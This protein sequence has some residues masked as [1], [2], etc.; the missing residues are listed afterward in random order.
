MV[1]PALAEVC[2]QAVYRLGVCRFE[3][4]DM[5]EAVT[6]FEQLLSEFP[7]SLL[8]ASASFFCGEACTRLGR[9]LQAVK[10]LQ[11]VAESFPSDP[12]CGPAMLRLGEAQAALQRWSQSEEVFGRYLD[13]FADSQVW[14]QAR[15]G[16]GWARE[17]QG[18]HDEAIDAYRQV[19]NRHQGPT[20]ARAQFQIGE[21][22]FAKKDYDNAIRELLKVDILYAHPQWSAA[23]LY[24]AGRCFEA[25]SQLGQARRQFTQ[26][27][28][29]YDQT[30]WAQ[31]A[32]TR[33]TELARS[34]PPNP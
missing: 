14:F 6:L 34:S 33:L 17:N 11:R 25:L 22:L 29:K 12:A 15:F 19:V 3:L 27:A 23:A 30:R 4:G 24:E 7:E 10:H 20:A 21:C 9:H 1:A 16:M 31:L 2:E 28:E 13:R 8:L 18:R 5:S 32:A 26:V